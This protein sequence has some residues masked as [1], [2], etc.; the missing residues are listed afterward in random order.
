MLNTD[1]IKLA[2]SAL[3]VCERYGI[4]VNRAGFAR[5][6][7]HQEK[8]PSMKVYRGDRGWHCFGCGKGGDVI[9]LTQGI[10]GVTF[11]GAC[12]RLN[13]DFNLGLNIG[14][15][16]S[17]EE[18]IKANKEFWERKKAKE[19]VERDHK[20]LIADFNNAVRLLRIMEEEVDT[21]APVDQNAEWSESFC[22]ALATTSFARQMVDEALDNLVEFEKT[23]YSRG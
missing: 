18:Q 9:S 11:S 23:M 17:K 13:D 14:K 22:Y 1:K 6:P 4:D 2:V 8:T 15:H 5:C 10:L 7:F 19:K 16:L 12:K 20:T 21:Q 3:D